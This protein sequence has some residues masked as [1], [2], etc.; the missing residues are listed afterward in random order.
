MRPAVLIFGQLEFDSTT[1]KTA[2]C[3]DFRFNAF[4]RPD[5]KQYLG[6]ESRIRARMLVKA[7]LDAGYN[8]KH[9][10][11]AI[12]IQFA[13]NLFKR[14]QHGCIRVRCAIFR[15]I[16]WS[17]KVEALFRGIRVGIVLRFERKSKRPTV[18]LLA[19]TP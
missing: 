11:T 2:F 3:T 4:H 15:V 13:H 19:L 7:L 18:G 6:S 16:R 5:K 10:V 12:R 1:V 8:L 14:F 9:F 17:T